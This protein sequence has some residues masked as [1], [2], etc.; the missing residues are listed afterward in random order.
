[1]PIAEARS[2][3]PLS[4]SS[5]NPKGELTI[6]RQQKQQE[7]HGQGVDVSRVP[8]QVE[9]KEPEHRR[10]VH[11]LEPVGAAGDAGKL[12]GDLAQHQRDAKGHHQAGQIGAAQHQEARDEAD[13]R[14]QCA[15]DQKRQHGLGDEPVFRKQPRCIS[16]DAEKRGL[17]ERNDPGIAEDEIEREREQTEDGGLGQDQMPA[18]EKKDCRDH[19]Q[20]ECDLQGRPARACG[21]ASSHL[22]GHLDSVLGGERMGHVGFVTSMSAYRTV[23]RPNKPCGRQISTTIMIV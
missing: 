10:N 22:G 13:D 6:W 3:L 12:V 9:A 16:T 1:M 4:D 21:E 19:R 15:G 2:G 8:I 7:Q 23:T 5:D 17:T 14:R 20:P 11:A 18:G